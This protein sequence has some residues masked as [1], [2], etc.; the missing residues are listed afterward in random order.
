MFVVQATDGFRR[1]I[2]GA[3]HSRSAVDMYLSQ[4]PKKQRSKQSIIDLAGLTY[5]LYIC[6]DEKG[7]HFLTEVEVITALKHYTNDLRHDDEDWCYTNLYRIVG[8]W[9][10]K[11]PGTDYMGSLPH[12]HVTNSTLEKVE[13]Y[14]FESL[15]Q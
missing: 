8:N 11:L 15:W 3:F 7:F 9:Q 13:Q 2:S 10:P 14:G 12:Y 1:W 6:E 4:I 5:P